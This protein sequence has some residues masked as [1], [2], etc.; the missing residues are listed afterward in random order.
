MK[1]LAG[2]TALSG[3]G[4]SVQSGVK[5]RVSWLMHGGVFA[6]VQHE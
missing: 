2:V 4:V 1:P 6:F 5:R 3:R